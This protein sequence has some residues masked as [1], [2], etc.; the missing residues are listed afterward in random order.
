M[1]E[2]AAGEGLGGEQEARRITPAPQNPKGGGD[3]LPSGVGTA[4]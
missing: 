3:S 4:K 2:S 1:Q